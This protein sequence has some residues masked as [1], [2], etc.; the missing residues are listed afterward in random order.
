MVVKLT[1]IVKIKLNL[2]IK[3]IHSSG[4][5][6]KSFNGTE[7]SKFYPNLSMLDLKENQMK[8]VENFTFKGLLEL[9]LLEISY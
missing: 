6:L 9:N 4:N 1:Y 8:K 3:S 5:Y 7:I 2:D